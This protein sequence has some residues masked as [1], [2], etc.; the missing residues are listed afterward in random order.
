[1][2]GPIILDNTVLSNL[3]IVLMGRP[4]CYAVGAGRACTM[5]DVMDEYRAAADVGV[6]PSACWDDL[7]V[8][9]MMED[10]AACASAHESTAGRGRAV[11]SGCGA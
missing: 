2:P 8:V 4:G 11:V 10:E 1:M 9:E 6:L 5:Q 7:I 3:A